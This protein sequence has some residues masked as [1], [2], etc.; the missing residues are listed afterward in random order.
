MPATSEIVG[1]SLRQARLCGCEEKWCRHVVT[2]GRICP[3]LAMGRKE[4][5]DALPPIK[6]L[7]VVDVV[8]KAPRRPE[9]VQRR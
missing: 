4:G 9:R 2:R 1:S 3:C 7:A 6:L 5:K 8:A